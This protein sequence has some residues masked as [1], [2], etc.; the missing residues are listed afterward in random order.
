ML[1]LQGKAA[2]S[3]RHN[4]TV[5]GG[6]KLGVI[7]STATGIEVDIDWH[8]PPSAPGAPGRADSAKHVPDYLPPWLQDQLPPVDQMTMSDL[9]KLNELTRDEDSNS[10]R[11][12]DTI[13]FST[14][15]QSKDNDCSSLQ[16]YMPTKKA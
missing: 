11:V 9:K 8:G 5:R 10:S 4:A 7:K 3:G 6:R 15:P 14:N 2:R 12:D 1:D 13:M 16:P